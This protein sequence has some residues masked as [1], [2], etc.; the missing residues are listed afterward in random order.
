MKHFP[1]SFVGA[2][3]RCPW[4]AALVGQGLLRA[5]V[6]WTWPSTPTKR[7]RITWSCLSFLARLRIHQ[8]CYFHWISDD[9]CLICDGIQVRGIRGVSVP[10]RSSSL[11]FPTGGTC[12]LGFGDSSALKPLSLSPSHIFPAY[13]TPAWSRYVKAKL[14]RKSL[15]TRK[16]KD[17]G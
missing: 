10:Q 17:N 6:V 4:V 12:H 9:L 13:F 5:R 1:V 15:E 3:G 7:A 2:S 16:R 14:L 8:G 11:P